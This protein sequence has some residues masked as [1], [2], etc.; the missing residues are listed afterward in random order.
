MNIVRAPTLTE[1]SLIHVWMLLLCMCEF[2]RKQSSGGWEP[3]LSQT[4]VI[5]WE[6]VAEG[7]EVYV[8]H[9]DGRVRLKCAPECEAR[10]FRDTYKISTEAFR[11]LNR[12][13]CPVAIAAGTEEVTAAIEAEAPLI[14]A[15]IPG[16]R[17]EK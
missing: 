4:E 2:S 10:V 13:A 11:G 16:G 3:P 17:F 5:N 12:L 1:V 9:A 7:S 15:Q 6:T 8:M 14:A